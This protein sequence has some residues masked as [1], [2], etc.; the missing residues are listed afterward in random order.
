MCSLKWDKIDADIACMELG[1][2]QGAYRVSE[3]GDFGEGIGPLLMEQVHCRGGERRLTN[4]EHLRYTSANCGSGFA[5]GVVCR[6]NTGMLSSQVSFLTLS[7]F[8]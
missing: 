4:C 8:A 1:F 5:A 2:T 7:K 3:E 6:P